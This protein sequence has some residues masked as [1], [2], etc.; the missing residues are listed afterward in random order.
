MS[1]DSDFEY[2]P[3]DDGYDYEQHFAKPEHYA[4]GTKSHMHTH[5]FV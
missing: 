2:F 5:T 4:T 1:D 3:N